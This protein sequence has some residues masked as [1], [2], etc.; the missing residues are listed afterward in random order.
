M[1]K[2]TLLDM[3]LAEQ[4]QRLAARRHA[5]WLPPSGPGVL[6]ASTSSPGWPPDVGGPTPHG[7]PTGPDGT[8]PAGASPRTRMAS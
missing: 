1:A 3:P 8:P 7:A 5:L 4:A 6:P 2:I